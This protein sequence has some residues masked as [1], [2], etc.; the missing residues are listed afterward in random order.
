M[1]ASLCN[2]NCQHWWSGCRCI[3]AAQNFCCLYWRGAVVTVTCNWTAWICYWYVTLVFTVRDVDGLLHNTL[4]ASAAHACLYCLT[5]CL[6]HSWPVSKL[7]NFVYRM[8]A[9]HSSFFLPNIIVKFPPGGTEYRLLWNI[10]IFNHCLPNRYCHFVLTVC[11]NDVP[12][13]HGFW[14]ITFL[15]YV[16]TACNVM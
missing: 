16:M 12:I 7:W 4:H 10:A 6:S 1:V 5:I 15:A 14:N 2:C 11:S 3:L 8:V 9:H 13:L